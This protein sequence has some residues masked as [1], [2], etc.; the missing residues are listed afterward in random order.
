[1]KKRREERDTG[2][3]YL[4]MMYLEIIIIEFSLLFIKL[5]V[6]MMHA[7]LR[8]EKKSFTVMKFSGI[9]RKEGEVNKVFLEW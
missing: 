1:M 8:K 5:F 3:K 7:R 4:C 9:S 2:E 6:E